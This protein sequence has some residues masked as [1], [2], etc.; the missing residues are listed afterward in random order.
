MVL[1]VDAV[2]GALLGMLFFG[3]LY[4][5]VRRGLSSRV[6]ALYF[7]ASQF[8]RTASVLTGFWFVSAGSWKRLTACL[9][10]FALVRVVA[11]RFVRQKD[12][13]PLAAVTTENRNAP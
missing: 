1:A 8:L 13:M 6:P 2:V 9:V 5:T 12:G 4:V 11:M 7:P 10:G 3:G